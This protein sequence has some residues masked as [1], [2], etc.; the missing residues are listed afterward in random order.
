M[1][2]KTLANAISAS[3][4]ALKRNADAGWIAEVF[5]SGK[6]YNWAVRYLGAANTHPDRNVVRKVSVNHDW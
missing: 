2:Y 1:A 6:K 4:S 3:R 5:K